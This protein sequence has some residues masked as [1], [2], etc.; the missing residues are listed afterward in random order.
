MFVPIC[1]S[2][3]EYFGLA[4]IRLALQDIDTP[5]I[6]FE[7]ICCTLCHS[8][9]PLVDRSDTP[10]FLWL[11]CTRFY[12]DLLVL[13]GLLERDPQNARHGL[14]LDLQI[15]T[16]AIRDEQAKDHDQGHVSCLS[17]V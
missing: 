12:S 8:N 16:Y 5:R 9:L 3:N 1:V 13:V 7:I 4:I 17:L 6:I 11:I 2:A 15:Y 10:I 14:I